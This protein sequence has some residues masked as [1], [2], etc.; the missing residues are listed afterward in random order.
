MQSAD[1][2]IVNSNVCFMASAEPYF[3]NIIK[4]YDMQLSLF[5]L[6]SVFCVYLGRLYYDVVVSWLLNLKNLEFFVTNGI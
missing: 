4:I 5:F 6:F 2:D 1:R 3:V